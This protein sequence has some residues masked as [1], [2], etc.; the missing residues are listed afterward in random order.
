MPM[1]GPVPSQPLSSSALQSTHRHT[2]ISRLTETG[3]EL[4]ETCL[5]NK[6]IYQYPEITVITV[7][8]R[9]TE[10]GMMH[11]VNADRDY[12]RTFPQLVNNPI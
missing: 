8:G 3:Y 1:I 7:H 12:I 2:T 4:H 5:D 10:Q 11:N 9:V 6:V